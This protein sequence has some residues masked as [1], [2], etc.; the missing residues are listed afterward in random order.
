MGENNLY[1]EISDIVLSFEDFKGLRF[2][3]HIGK[4]TKMFLQIWR[5]I[6]IA[7][8]SI[9]VINTML[10]MQF[11]KLG[12]YRETKEGMV[13]FHF[14][15]SILLVLLL[16]FI[17]FVLPWFIYPHIENKYLRK[18]YES[19]SFIK[20][21]QKYIFDD[22]KFKVIT[23]NG[24]NSFRWDEV[25]E[26]KETKSF[27]SIWVSKFHAFVIPRRY[28]EYRPDIL[29]LIKCKVQFKYYI[30]KGGFTISNLR[31]SRIQ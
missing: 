15:P 22:L 17:L 31:N 9:L 13:N 12:G 10:L 26:V 21:P 28:I 4:K 18:M 2:I 27:L 5:G 7:Y 1:C 16:V 23:L 25:M 8:V 30:V 19:N 11:S 20:R 14:S 24:E 29:N 6:G 3:S